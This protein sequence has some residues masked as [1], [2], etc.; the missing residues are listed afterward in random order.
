ME[1]RDSP[2][3]AAWRQEVRGFL[4]REAP[5]VAG[6]DPFEPEE[7]AGLK[8]WRNKLVERGWIAPAWP[9]QYGGAGLSVVEQFILN[10]E[11]AEARAPQM[12]G[13]GVGMLGP[14]LI[15]YGTDE[16]KQ[17]HLS[18]ILKGE[19]RWCQGYSEPGA[20]SD[21]AS[22]QTRAIRDGDD[23][24]INGQKIWTSGA[25]RADWM[26]MLART[27]P[28]APKHRGISYFLL[29]MKTPGITVRP[30]INMAGRHLFNEVFFED[31]RVP[32]RNVVGEVN[33]G[34]YVGATTLDFERSS[35]GNSVGQRQL[36]ESYLAHFRG[37]PHCL[38]EAVRAK[39]AELWIEA[40]VAKLLSYHVISLQANGG[41]PN[42]EASIAK[43]FNS[44]LS[45]RIANAAVGALRLNGTI[46]DPVRAPLR[47]QA[48]A[49]YM[50]R[51]SATI[52]GGSSEVQRNIIATRGLGLPRA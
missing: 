29:D 4:K 28:D 20:G 44:E 37:N 39:F 49:A 14:T 24:V 46:V 1:F 36:I 3:Q 41:V 47:A 16:Q 43:L 6:D 18:R 19:A 10:E 26:F 27:D 34:W 22:L 13:G 7:G 11:F 32:A 21:L 35:I 40:N 25:H 38:T 17:E 50:G 15:Q 45:Q 23:F 48:P 31:A 12:G 42:H 5:G 51:V 33:R 52:A 30:L 9:K 8:R 2:V